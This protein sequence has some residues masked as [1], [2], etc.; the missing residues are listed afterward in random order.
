MNASSANYAYLLT[1]PGTGALALIRLVGPDALAIASKVFDPKVGPPLPET[2]PG[3]LRYGFIRD[4][5]E[6]VD[7]VVVAARRCED[8]WSIDI[9]AHGGVRV[10]ERLLEVL[11]AA[12]AP[13]RDSAAL[14]LGLDRSRSTL[15]QEITECLR[16]AGTPRAVRFL[17]YQRRHLAETLLEAARLLAT[18]PLRAREIIE[19]ALSG[20][21]AS[22]RLIEGV[23][24]ALVG[25]ANSGKS[26][27]FNRLVG[28]ESATVSPQA[29][30]TRDWVSQLVDMDGLPVTLI[31][32]AGGHESALELEREAL[33]AG[34]RQAAAAEL[35]I[36]LLDGSMPE[37]VAA[38]AL[39]EYG[40]DEGRLIAI[41]KIDSAEAWT[42]KEATALGIADAVMVSAKT[43]AR[44]D[45][46][47]GRIHEKLGIDSLSE[48]RPT[49]FT[50]RQARLA[51]ELLSGR[52]CDGLASDNRIQTELIGMPIRDSQG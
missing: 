9:S 41:N 47:A 36:L 15:D 3:H 21:E 12:G 48:P 52:E 14:S 4:G 23:T 28:R 10:V 43:G 34:R 51:R 50:P 7:D 40:P 38:Q 13:L 22:R 16:Q 26:T 18:E 46:L 42:T 35:R 11:E 33:L 49:L 8:G 32:T 29:G 25:P 31:D 20:H 6:R 19:G 39:A 27:L 24:V 17:A 1:P 5:R 30:T 45:H 37:E 2:P 44:V